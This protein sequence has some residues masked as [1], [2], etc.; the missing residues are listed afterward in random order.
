ML[1]IFCFAKH[2]KLLHHS[3]F[4]PPAIPKTTLI[5]NSFIFIDAARVEHKKKGEKKTSEELL[6]ESTS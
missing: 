5:F 4:G 6:S 3:R 2:K 1:K